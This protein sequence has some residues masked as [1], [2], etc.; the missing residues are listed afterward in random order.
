MDFN[1]P[2]I[3]SKPSSTRKTVK[4]AYYDMIVFSPVR[5][6]FI[7]QRPQHMVSRMAKKRNVLFVEMPIDFIP[8]EK[9]TVDLI[10]VNQQITVLRPKIEHL[11]DLAQL[12]PDYVS[13]E[14]VPI[15]LFYA[16]VFS[17]LL[18]VFTFD[19]V[20]YDC[21]SESN[22]SITPSFDL[23]ERES[24][25]I[26]EA[27]LILAN[28]QL[29]YDSKYESNPNVHCLPNLTNFYNGKTLPTAIIDRT[30]ERMEV[31]IRSC[32]NYGVLI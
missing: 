8:E 4:A 28:E 6:N 13:N 1:Q 14:M 18:D 24:H 2:P 29:I 10:A 31:L 32:R 19:K 7:Y 22:R 27:D 12:L 20:V 26:A 15:G 3:L 21:V 5:W 17:P 9:N 11:D 30:A 16:P 25:L 23:Q